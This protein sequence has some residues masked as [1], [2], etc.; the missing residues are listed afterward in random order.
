MKRLFLVL[1]AVGWLLVGSGCAVEADG[2]RYAG[3]LVRLAGVLGLCGL[4]VKVAMVEYRPRRHYWR[5]QVRRQEV[6]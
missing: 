6:G 1:L 3:L 2:V 5:V 4:G